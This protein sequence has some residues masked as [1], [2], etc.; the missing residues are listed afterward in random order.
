MSGLDLSKLTA[1]V[2]RDRTV[3]E[4]ASRRSRTPWLRTP[5]RR[6]SFMA[7]ALHRGVGADFMSITIREPQRDGFPFNDKTGHTVSKEGYVLWSESVSVSDAV[8]TDR[9]MPVAYMRAVSGSRKSYCRVEGCDAFTW[10]NVRAGYCATHL[11]FHL[12]GAVQKEKLGFP[13]MQECKCE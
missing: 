10:G 5:R 3:N 7:P 6:S 4:S 13:P 1:A 11:L 2:E 12:Q 9:G 8:D